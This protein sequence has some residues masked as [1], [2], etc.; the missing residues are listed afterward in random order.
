[1]LSESLEAQEY[2]A[3]AQ[4]AELWIKDN[5]PVAGSTDYGKDEDMAEVSRT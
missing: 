5:E 2:F 3:D 4:E 1:M